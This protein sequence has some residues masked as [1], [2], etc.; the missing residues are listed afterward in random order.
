MELFNCISKTILKDFTKL[1]VGPIQ[2]YLDF[3]ISNKKLKHF[4]F[5]EV[6]VIIV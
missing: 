3:F 1:F 2:I 6:F 5:D 4:S